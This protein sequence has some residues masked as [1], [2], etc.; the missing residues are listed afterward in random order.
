[1]SVTIINLE[2]HTTPAVLSTTERHD[3]ARELTTWATGQIARSQT[4]TGAVRAGH[5][6]NAARAL[7]EAS[8]LLHS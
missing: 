7:D 4:A 1:M 6:A 5:L 3:K 2:E 8:A